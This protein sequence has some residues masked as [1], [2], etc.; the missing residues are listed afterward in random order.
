VASQLHIARFTDMATTFAPAE[1]F[2]KD[3]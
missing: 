2:I 3:N 1:K